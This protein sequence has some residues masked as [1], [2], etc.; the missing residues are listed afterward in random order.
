[1]L[2]E[3][4]VGMAVAVGSRDPN[5]FAC[6][7]VHERKFGELTHTFGAEVSRRQVVFSFFQVGF[8]VVVISKWWTG[9]RKARRESA[10]FVLHGLKKE[11]G[12]EGIRAFSMSY[13]QNSKLEGELCQILIFILCFDSMG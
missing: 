1:V 7:P 3:E 13:F 6:C 5:A 11:K 8:P 9:K 10:P 4:V 2:G 12:A